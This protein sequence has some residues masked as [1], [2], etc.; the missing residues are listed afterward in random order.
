MEKTS[1]KQVGHA[2]VEE[3]VSEWSRDLESYDRSRHTVRAYVGAVRDFLLWY[4]NEEGRL[5]DLPDLTPIAL[6]GYRNELQ[7]EQGKPTSTVNTR[8]AGLRSFCRW[9]VER[10]HLPV[11]PS[12]RLGSVG[13][14]G[15]PAPKGLTDR[16]VNALLQEAS[17]GRHGGREYALVQVLLQT[18]MR[19]G[20]CAV[21]DYEDIVFGER[22]GAVTI[23]AGKGNKAR[24]V[25]LNAS[26]RQALAAYVAPLLGVELSMSAVAK[27]W[28]KRRSGVP[29][30]PLWSSQKGGHL[31]A[32][33]IRR[34]IDC[35][36]GAASGKGLLPADA[37]AHTAAHLRDVL[38]Q[39]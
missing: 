34:T 26:V 39:G 28:P 15:P 14:Q 1:D 35:M 7:H 30:T 21:L 17:R 25:P 29:G 20:E 12:S 18:G 10:G 8:L 3:L 22:G 11:D 36:V 13:R 5:P 19:I 31:S 33:A 32:Q 37:S 23:R 27:A 2:G 9:L 16:Q 6:L 38:P 4:S 24:G